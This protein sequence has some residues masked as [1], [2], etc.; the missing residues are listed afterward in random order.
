MRDWPGTGTFGRTGGRFA[1]GAARRAGPPTSEMQGRAEIVSED[2]RLLERL[3]DRFR[4]V[5][6][7]DVS[8]L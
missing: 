6:V 1:V 7:G 3:F 8:G 5:P 4:K 2:L